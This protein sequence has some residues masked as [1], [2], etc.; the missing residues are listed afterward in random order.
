MSGTHSALVGGGGCGRVACG[1]NWIDDAVDEQ[2]FARAG[3]SSGDAISQPDARAARAGIAGRAYGTELVL[4][5]EEHDRPVAAAEQLVGA[6]EDRLQDFLEVEDEIHRLGGL[7][8][9]AHLA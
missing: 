1:A 3:H 2:R 7:E 5:M 6:F 8:E 4:T 9:R